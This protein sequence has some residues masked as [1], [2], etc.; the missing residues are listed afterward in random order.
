MAFIELH[1]LECVQFE[2]GVTQ[3]TGWRALETTAAR[4]DAGN[5][6]AERVPWQGIREQY[7]DDLYNATVAYYSSRRS[8]T[9]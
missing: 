7:G 6:F 9:A 4:L 1:P 5:R 3:V 2:S 8:L